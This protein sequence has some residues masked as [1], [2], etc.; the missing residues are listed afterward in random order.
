VIPSFDSSN[1]E[2]LKSLLVPLLE[3]YQY[4][5]ARSRSL[6]ESQTIHF[7]TAEQQSELL[8]R[9]LTAQQEVRTAQLLFQATGG[10]VGVETAVLTP[11]HQLVM[12]CWQVSMRLRREESTEKEM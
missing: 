1:P 4:W 8:Q 9:V 12:D 11:W 2:L 3:D 5:F 7:L 10:Q 6:L